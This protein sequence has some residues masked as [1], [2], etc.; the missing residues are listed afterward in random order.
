[1]NFSPG[2]KF[3]NA[4]G[5]GLLRIECNTRR[6]TLNAPTYAKA[7][8]FA[9]ASADKSVGRPRASDPILPPAC[10]DHSD[11]L[12]DLWNGDDEAGAVDQHIVDVIVEALGAALV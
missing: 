11:L 2:N 9:K 4:Y 12:A 3:A 10:F 5:Q 1:M 8:P 6:F 7:S